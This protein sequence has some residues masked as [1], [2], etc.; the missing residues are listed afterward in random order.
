[1]DKSSHETVAYESL[2]M[3]V[4]HG[5]HARTNYVTN[6]SEIIRCSAADARGTDMST[7]ARQHVEKSSTNVRR[8]QSRKPGVAGGLQLWQTLQ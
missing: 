5:N 6:I 8:H 3:F 7:A 1:M 4:Q 2:C